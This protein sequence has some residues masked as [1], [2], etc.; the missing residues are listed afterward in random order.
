[1]L[2]EA[3]PVGRRSIT[4]LIFTGN[5]DAP[6]GDWTQGW[7]VVLYVDVLDKDSIISEALKR[8]FLFSKR[9]RYLAMTCDRGLGIETTPEPSRRY[10]GGAAP[11]QISKSNCTIFRNVVLLH[12]GSLISTFMDWDLG[13]RINF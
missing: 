13:R 11:N 7:Q 9:F 5:L 12:K 8:Y 3:T 2:E 1:L 6:H 10:R 4:T